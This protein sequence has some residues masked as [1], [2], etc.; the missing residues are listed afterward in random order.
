MQGAMFGTPEPWP[1]L[2][3]TL[4][5]PLAT[6]G[7]PKPAVALNSALWL[8]CLAELLLLAQPGERWLYNTGSQVLG[9]LAT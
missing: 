1:I 5:R 7:P 6:F 9:V 4:Q 8:A 3:A 2:T